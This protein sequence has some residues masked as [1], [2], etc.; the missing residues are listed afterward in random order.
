MVFERL[1]QGNH[2]NEELLWQP[3]HI[4]LSFY[5][6]KDQFVQLKEV[7]VVLWEFVKRL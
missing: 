5:V 3:L 2:Q 6:V 7:S 4:G 1:E